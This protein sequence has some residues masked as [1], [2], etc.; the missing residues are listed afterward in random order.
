MSKRLILACA[1]IIGGGSLFAAGFFL[2]PVIMPEEKA[3]LP[4]AEIR[5]YDNELQWFDGTG[6][7]GAGSAAAALQADPFKNEQRPD[8]LCSSGADSGTVRKVASVPAAPAKTS[9]SSGK[10]SQS[11]T[12]VNDGEDVWSGDIL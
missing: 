10:S 4:T 9:K 1:A 8:G 12:K 5:I 3:A 2:R 7:T 6:W 11:K